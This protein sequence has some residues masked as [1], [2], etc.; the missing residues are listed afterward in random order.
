MQN[1][2]FIFT[3]P[4]TAEEQARWAGAAAAAAAPSQHVG[5]DIEQMF[6]KSAAL[7]ASNLHILNR[8][9]VLKMRQRRR[10]HVL[11]LLLFVVTCAPHF[12][13]SVFE[14]A[15]SALFS[16]AFTTAFCE[17][18]ATGTPRLQQSS[19]RCAAHMMTTQRSWNACRST[20][21]AAALVNAARLK[22]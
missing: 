1:P 19:S 12:L 18:F 22:M 6:K 5:S 21:H 4:I 17:F 20:R 3:A 2:H 7:G 10:L 15:A 16:F 13:L 11:L 8:C 9:L 14:K